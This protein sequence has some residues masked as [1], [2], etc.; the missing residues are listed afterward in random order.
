[1]S[2][3]PRIVYWTSLLAIVGGLVC[4]TDRVHARQPAPG[5]LEGQ[6]IDR[7]GQPVANIAVVLHRVT[8]DGG[9]VVGQTT[10][11]EGGRFRIEAHADS[12]T[13]GVY[14]VAVR[15]EGQLHIG[16]MIQP[17][18][19]AGSDY[20]VQIGAAAMELGSS[21]AGAPAAAPPTDEGHGRG[22]LLVIGL[23]GGV[24]AALA[25]IVSRRPSARRRLLIR[26]A[27]EEEDAAAGS[28][29]GASA[30]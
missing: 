29:P 4:F 16:P 17:P 14:F 7:A 28:R 6:V 1:L 12:L 18:F 20:V 27:R 24:L 19:P 3:A 5:V 8:A 10:S 9:A 13:E 23:I 26:I 25:V 30:S 2:I 15:Y 22:P 11:E 21:P